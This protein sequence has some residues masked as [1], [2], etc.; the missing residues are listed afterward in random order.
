MSLRPLF[1]LL[2]GGCLL[3]PAFGAEDGWEEE[4]NQAPGSI[5][6]RFV[7]PLTRQENRPIRSLLN[8]DQEHASS[9]GPVLTP[10]QPVYVR[11]FQSQKPGPD[12]VNCILEDGR[13][14]VNY[15]EP[16]DLMRM[17]GL[18]IRPVDGKT[19][20]PFLVRATMS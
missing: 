20:I 2:L 9:I 14:F 5:I 8:S 15:D 3:Q 17:P 13:I 7:D 16:H 18:R 4:G 12:E 10:G 19:K 6:K 11:Y 1:L